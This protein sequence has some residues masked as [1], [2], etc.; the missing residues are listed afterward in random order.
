MD[1]IVNLKFHRGDKMVRSFSFA[2]PPVVPRVGE[3]ILGEE[4][5]YVVTKVTHEYFIPFQHDI[6]IALEEK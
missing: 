3:E 6:H 5:L 2:Q 4:K 1:G